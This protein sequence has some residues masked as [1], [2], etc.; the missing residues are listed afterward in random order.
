QEY[1]GIVVPS[2]N[3]VATYLNNDVSIGYLLY[4]DRNGGLVT[5][6]TPTA[7]VQVLVP[8]N[9]RGSFPDGF[10]ATSF[11]PFTSNGALPAAPP[12]NPFTFTDQVFVTAGAEI[13]LGE[14]WSA[15]ANIVIPVAG[16]RGYNLGATFSLNY[17]Y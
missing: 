3:R 5:S 2:D 1:F 4:R 16:P 11:V 17:F 8:L 6:V 7:S 9:H 13:G 12:P 10:L 15:S 14:R